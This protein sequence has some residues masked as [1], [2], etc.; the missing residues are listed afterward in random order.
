M[1]TCALVSTFFDTFSACT[2]T[3]VNFSNKYNILSVFFFVTLLLTVDGNTALHRAAASGHGPAFNC[4]ISHGADTTSVNGK[5]ENPFEVA[6]K[7]GHSV[8]MENASM[9][10]RYQLVHFTLICIQ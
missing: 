2:S 6:K 1:N 3:V 5:G 7:N 10:D 9:Q 8:L 4:L